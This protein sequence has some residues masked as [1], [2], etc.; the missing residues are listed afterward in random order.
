MAGWPVGLSTGCF[1]RRSIFDV[2]E[3]VRQAGFTRIEVCS[4]PAH[5][6][7]GD[8]AAVERLTGML[9]RLGLE[10]WSFHA[11]F[12]DALDISAPDRRARGHARRELTRAA[13]AAAHLGARYLVVHPGPET[14]LH[15]PAAEH[16][17]RLVHAAEELAALGRRC[18]E[19]G[20]RMLLEN[21]LPHLV[22]GPLENLLWLAGALGDDHDGLCFDTG[23]AHLAGG[24]PE[25]LGSLAGRLRMLHVHDNRG[26][27]DDHLPPGCGHIDWPHLLAALERS[28]F[29][30]GL[31]VELG[32]GGGDVLE[33][34][35][36][37]WRRLAELSPR[38]ERV[39]PPGAAV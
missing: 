13:E 30:G 33:G 8:R 39:G 6:D 26:Q 12:S 9:R 32:E 1:Y 23:H 21:M 25:I 15:L 38:V 28:G 34:A 35:R 4:Y 16:R 19:L 20:L 11:P 14:V 3:P 22:F 2:L 31:I 5:L 10:A 37:G 17:E 29:A 18:R 7:Y 27:G 24:A 36:Q